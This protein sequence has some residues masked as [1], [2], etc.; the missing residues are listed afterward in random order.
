MK[1]KSVLSK[2]FFLGLILIAAVA[3][4]TETKTEIQQSEVVVTEPEL[5]VNNIITENVGKYPRDINLFENEEVVSRLKFLTGENYLEMLSN[6][7]VET[8]IVSENG[9]YKV[10]G[11]KQHDCPAYH[12]TIL[13]DAHNDNMN[14][15]INQDGKIKG[16][17][18]KATIDLTE[19]LEML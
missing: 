16:F 19:T 11:C 12:T 14:V 15:L 3:C 1:M 2:V 4:K 5:K 10:T 7:N 18:E 17:A 13:F 9:I 6:F 8:P